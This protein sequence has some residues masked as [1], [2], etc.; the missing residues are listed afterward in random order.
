METR[1]IV[2]LCGCLLVVLAAA[3]GVP[4]EEFQV[5]EYTTSSQGYAAISHDP[6]G[7]FVVAWESDYQ[8]GS[9]WGIFGRRFDSSGNAVGGDFQ[10]NLVTIFPQSRPAIS[11]DPSGG[12]VV[13]WHSAF[14]D[15]EEN[16]VFG[17]RFDSSGNAVGV[18]FQVNLYTT[19]RQ[20]FPTVSHDSLGGFVL[21]WESFG[22]D[23][24]SY[25][26]F[27]RRF[28]SSGNALGGEF[29]VNLH[30][31]YAQSRPRISQDPSGGF[32]VAWQSYAQDGSGSGVF[33]RRFDSGGNALGPDFTVNQ[34]LTGNQLF[35]AIS[36]DPSGGFVVAWQ[37][38]G[39][40]G[41]H[42]GIFGRRFD[43]SGNA[44]GAE[45]Q[46][47]QYTTE[48]QRYPTI[49]QDPS[50]GFVVAW[51]S[52]G[53]EG[54]GLGEGIFGRRFDSSGNALGAEFQVNQYT[55]SSQRRPAISH[56]PS[57]G[58]V[59]V[60]QSISQDGSLYGVFGRRF[61]APVPTVVSGPAGG[62]ASLVR[63]YQV[64]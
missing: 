47:N 36:Q 1:Q 54:P 45:F 64:E 50:G 39:Q 41:S 62:G 32:V 6:S 29:R 43:S 16:G 52:A 48:R 33:V 21:A 13:A 42:Y 8:D 56:D 15:G 26:I 55:I 5:N 51:E 53:Q 44:L 34:Y 18:D 7:G 49:S 12:F 60:W 58:F 2:G 31:T 40:D 23:G 4:A 61:D 38:Y 35:P 3:R 17:R 22:Q 20:V 28:D 10:V 30:T 63:R 27:G 59:V 19:S 14:Q 24:G 25:G 37:S 46:V 57:A 11:Q 9:S